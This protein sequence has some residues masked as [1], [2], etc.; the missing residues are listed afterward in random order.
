MDRRH[1]IKVGSIAGINLSLADYMYLEANDKVSKNAKADSVIYIYLPGGYAT[2]ETFDPKPL[3]PEEY[4][5]PLQSIK[6]AIEGVEFNEFFKETAKIADKISIIRSM[7]HGETAHERGRHDMFT[8]Y[9]PSAALTYASF[10]SIVSHELGVRNNLPPYIAIPEIADEYA[11]AG[12]LSHAY[13]PFSLGSRP[14]D[15]NFK[16]RDL[17]LPDGVTLDRFEKRKNLRSIVSKQFEEKQ[18]ADTVFSMDNFYEN[19]YGL[20]GSKPAVEAFDLSQENNKTK[21]AYGKNAAGMRM[22]LARRLV[23]AG[24]RFVTVTYGQWDMHQNIERGISNNVPS[25]DKAYAA[26]INDLDDR[27]MLDKTL[28]CIATEFGRTPKINTDAGRDHWPKV[29]STVMAGGGIKRGYV[30]GSSDQTAT[31]VFDK[32]VTP[33]DWGATIYNLLGIDYN[34]HLYAPGDRPI[35]IIDNGKVVN[36]IIA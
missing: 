19:A 21:E 16:V 28:V 5:G 22:L 10:G 4:K 7:T 6:T 18:S 23:E 31:D 13:S 11:G 29:F 3:S 32:P 35:K 17:T 25:F 14:E 30:H 2:Q 36:D 1:F 12:Y 24:T 34:N 33:E 8:G 20:L 26:L 15:K 9:R 27:G